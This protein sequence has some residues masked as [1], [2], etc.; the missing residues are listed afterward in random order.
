MKKELS[1]SAESLGGVGHDN[2]R[3]SALLSG[4]CPCFSYILSWLKSLQISKE[5]RWRWPDK[6]AE[7]SG[8]P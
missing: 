8:C 5:F 1:Y 7:R 2:A 3:S 4:G 6:R